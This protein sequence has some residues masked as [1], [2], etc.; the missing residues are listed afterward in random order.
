[1]TD[2]THMHNS[3]AAM[4]SLD[5]FGKTDASREQI[6]KSDCCGNSAPRVYIENYMEAYG[7][8][9]CPFCHIPFHG[10]RPSVKRS[11]SF[12]PEV[13]SYWAWTTVDW[14]TP[15]ENEEIHDYIAP[16]KDAEMWTQINIDL[17]GYDGASSDNNTDK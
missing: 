2:F 12:E 14:A 17:S 10:K 15:R 5:T 8:S 3:F 13:E 9:V 7:S 6:W 4:R 16:K 11:I 1:M